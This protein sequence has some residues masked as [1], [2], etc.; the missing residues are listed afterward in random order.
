MKRALRSSDTQLFFKSDG[1]QTTNID[2]AQSF[3]GF[4]DAVEFCREHKL[5]RTELIFRTGR[6]EDDL[7]VKIDDDSGSGQVV[8]WWEGQTPKAN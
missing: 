3:Q 8:K 4:G 7:R 2:E 5:K 1:L 6:P